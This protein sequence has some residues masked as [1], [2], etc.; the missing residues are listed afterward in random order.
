MSKR[1]G[2]KP[3]SRAERDYYNRLIRQ[4][5]FE[6]T[7]SESLDFNESNDKDEDYSIPTSSKRR[8]RSFGDI[9]RDHVSEK[10]AEYIF[11]I[12]GIILL[13]LM[14]NSKVDL[15]TIKEQISGLQ[16]DSD[17]I[18]SDLD[19]IEEKIN[20]NYEKLHKQEIQ[21]NENRFNIENLKTQETKAVNRQNVSND[22]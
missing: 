2:R 8:K 17:R 7:K 15:A 13:F 22:N 6:P 3:K 16:E 20:E 18:E 12:I 21:I 10:K 11:G 1:G 9:I 4:Q 19:E 14:V 5:D